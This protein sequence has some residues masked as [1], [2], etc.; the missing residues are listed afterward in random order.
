MSTRALRFASNLLDLLNRIL[1]SWIGTV[2]GNFHEVLL[3]YTHLGYRVIAL[4]YRT[5]HRMSYV[6]M[7]KAQ[8]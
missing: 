7:Q 3:Q 4:A 1:F 8:R 5:L 6:K 2:P